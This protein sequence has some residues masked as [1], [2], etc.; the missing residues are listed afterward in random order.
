MEKLSQTNTPLMN[1]DYITIDEEKNTIDIDEIIIKKETI[2]LIVFIFTLFLI[3]LPLVIGI[4]LPYKYV[5]ILDSKKKRITVCQKNIFG[6]VIGR[7]KIY[8]YCHINKIRLY[9][10]SGHTFERTIEKIYYINCDIFSID[11]EQDKLFNEIRYDE[12]KFKSFAEYFEKHLNIKVESVDIQKKNTNL[13][14]VTDNKITPTN[15]DN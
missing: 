15:N 7:Q 3:P 1:N 8:D 2:V 4:G 13:N 10:S 6:C 12:F 14:N 11:G 9:V 5:V